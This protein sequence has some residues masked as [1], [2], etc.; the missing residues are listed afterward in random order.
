MANAELLKKYRRDRIN[1]VDASEFLI[2]YE[3]LVDIMVS[4]QEWDKIVDDGFNY[5]GY[6]FLWKKTR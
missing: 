6:C 3:S 5:N 2:V 1:F 4:T